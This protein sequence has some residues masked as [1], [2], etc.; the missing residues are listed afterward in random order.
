MSAV[1]EAQPGTQLSP[2]LTP[3][4]ATHTPRVTPAITHPKLAPSPH[5]GHG[6]RASTRHDSSRR[7]RKGEGI[8]GRPVERRLSL[9]RLAMCRCRRT[10]GGQKAPANGHGETPINNAAFV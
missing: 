2:G 10:I 7:G 4:L 8:R 3:K 5:A 1:P 9:A 6:V